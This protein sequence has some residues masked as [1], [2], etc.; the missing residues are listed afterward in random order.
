[1]KT[2]L[3][4]EQEKYYKQCIEHVLT[5]EKGGTAV[6][7]NLVDIE[8]IIPQRK[9]LLLI[10]HVSCINLDEQTIT[11]QYTVEEGK[12]GFGGHFPNYPIWPGVLQVEAMGQT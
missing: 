6:D 3:S 11:A 12:D 9:P 1:M 7:L 5:P 10:D 4:P 8:A 2:L